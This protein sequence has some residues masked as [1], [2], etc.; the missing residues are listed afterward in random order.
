MQPI[1]QEGQEFLRVVLVGAFE[2]GLELAYRFLIS[3]QGQVSQQGED[4]RRGQ[5]HPKS[6]GSEERILL[7]PQSLYE[8]RHSICEHALCSERVRLV[9]SLFIRSL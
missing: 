6:H 3:E 4:V 7:A 9:D 1:E 8:L 2:P 5:T